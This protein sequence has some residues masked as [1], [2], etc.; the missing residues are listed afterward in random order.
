MVGVESCVVR[1]TSV[2]RHH[3][4]GRR[5]KGA[6]SLARRFAKAFCRIDGC[7]RFRA[8]KSA[9]WA[10]N[11]LTMR[12]FGQPAELT[13]SGSQSYETRAD[14]SFVDQVLWRFRSQERRVGKECVSTCRSRGSRVTYKQKETRKRNTILINE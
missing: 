6:S 2:A 10:A 4:S 7:S 3:N 9:A 8:R 12:C 1:R 14:S 5:G 11:D 13:A